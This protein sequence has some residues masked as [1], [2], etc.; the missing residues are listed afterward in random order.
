MHKNDSNYSKKMFNMS[1]IVLCIYYNLYL[2]FQLNTIK[3][4]LL[5]LLVICRNCW[6]WDI[7]VLQGKVTTQ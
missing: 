3:K 4:L 2:T 7:Y 6:L 1:S 5:D